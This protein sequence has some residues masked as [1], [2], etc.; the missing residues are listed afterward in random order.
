MSNAAEKPP[1]IPDPRNSPV[2]AQTLIKIKRMMLFTHEDEQYLTMAGEVLAPHAEDILNKWYERIV[3]N[4]YLANYFTQSGAPDLNYVHSLRPHFR[5]WISSL[6]RRSESMRW[7]EFEEKII[8]QLQLRNIPVDDLDPL[9][10]LFLRYLST[11]V[12]PVSEAGRYFLNNTGYGSDDIEKMHQAW[13]KAVSLSAL[14]WLYPGGQKP[15]F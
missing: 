15:P 9:S 13:F 3:S 7:W 10:P 4:N 12:F 11:F 5:E 1:V 2:D 8:R 14:L 6:C